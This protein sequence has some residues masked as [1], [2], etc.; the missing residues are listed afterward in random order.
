[1]V[2]GNVFARRS[3]EG[4]VEIVDPTTVTVHAPGTPLGSIPT[5]ALVA[6]LL[7]WGMEGD[8]IV[9]VLQRCDRE[10]AHAHRR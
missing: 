6:V 1:M 2:Y 10:V 8:D 5:D 9:D 4:E 3:E 7:A